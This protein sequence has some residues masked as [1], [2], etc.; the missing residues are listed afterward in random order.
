M[1]LSCDSTFSLHKS[2]KVNDFQN[3][4]NLINIPYFAFRNMVRSLK[5]VHKKYALWCSYT[6]ELLRFL[7]MGPH[8][9]SMNS[10]N[11]I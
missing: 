7:Y 6:C 5:I 11:C 3:K 1:T 10:Y 9:L 8:I 4:N 2:S